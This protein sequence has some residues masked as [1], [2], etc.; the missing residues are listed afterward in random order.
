MCLGGAC[1][2]SEDPNGSPTQDFDPKKGRGIRLPDGRPADETTH[3]PVEAPVPAEARQRIREL[4]ETMVQPPLDSTSD[5]H[6]KWFHKSNKLIAELREADESVGNA[7][8]HAF[9]GE[10]SDDYLTRRAL[11]SVGAHASPEA[12]APL[13]HELVF[14]Y[15]Y[16]IE[17]RAEAC[18][19]LPLADPRGYLEAA[20]E[21]L[22]R[23]GRVT[24]TMPNDEFLVQ[25][26]IEACEAVG[27]SPVEMC[28]DVATNLWREPMAR[29]IAASE[30]GNH[31][32]NPI[33]RRALET[34]LI[35][36]TG[37]GML[38]IKAAQAIGAGYP[39]ELACGLFEDVLEREV[40]MH[41]QDFLTSM[42][43]HYCDGE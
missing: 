41:M 40:S 25:S 4:I 33:A 37:D 12:A 32:A 21:Y 31:T 43:S 18:K 36:S 35:E 27:Q 20:E 17:D 38:R 14:T 1:S 28:A 22:T 26:W 16:R 11:L 5:I 39:R 19:L 23:R 9:C 29:Y 8:L 24:K 2:I 3:I 34:C 15:G 42:I 30:L 13:L 7:A 6:D 10:A